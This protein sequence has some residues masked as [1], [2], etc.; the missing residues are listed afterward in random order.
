MTLPSR[1]IERAEAAF[2]ARV[3]RQADASLGHDVDD[4]ADRAVAVQHGAAVAARDLDA[5]D[6][7]AR[8]RG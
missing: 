3:R 7:V 1:C 5:I 8:D 2:D 4:A 6:A